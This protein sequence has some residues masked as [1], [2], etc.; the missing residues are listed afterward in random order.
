MSSFQMDD[1]DSDNQF[2][3]S[4]LEVLI[5]KMQDYLEKNELHNAEIIAER[6]AQLDS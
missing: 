4:T 1:Y 5:D 2:L 6:I 3:N